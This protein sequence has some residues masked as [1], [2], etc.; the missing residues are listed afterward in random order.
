MRQRVADEYGHSFIGTEHIL[1]GLLAERH[2]MAGRVLGEL[3][4]VEEAIKRTRAIMESDGY[5]RS[6]ST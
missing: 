5:A 4:V 3:G 6:T 2:G 1:L